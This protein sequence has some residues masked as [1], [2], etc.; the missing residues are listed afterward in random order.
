MPQTARSGTP[1]S[2]RPNPAA[3]SHINGA[4]LA[5]LAASQSLAQE[6]FKLLARR[7]Q[8]YAAWAEA[9]SH[10][11]T[12]AEYFEA[13]SAWLARVPQDYLRTGAEIANAVTEKAQQAAQPK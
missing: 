5:P 13:Y 12:P 3:M 11:S 6:S 4:A 8:A 10:S 7:A 2:D 9:I 1:S